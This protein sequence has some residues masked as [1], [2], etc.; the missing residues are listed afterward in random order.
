V[1]VMAA[2]DEQILDV[3]ERLGLLDKF[4]RGSVICIASSWRR[5]RRAPQSGHRGIATVLI[6]TRAA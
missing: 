6:R 2:T 3:I 4:A 1:F 5:Y